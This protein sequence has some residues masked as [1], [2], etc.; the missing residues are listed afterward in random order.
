V[1]G[2]RFRW[3][4]YLATFLIPTAIFSLLWLVDFESLLIAAGFVIAGPANHEDVSLAIALFALSVVAVCSLGLVK[5]RKKQ[6]ETVARI[7]FYLMLIF[8][9][10]FWQNLYDLFS[11]LGLEVYV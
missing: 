9:C 8:A 6:S 7:L 11:R 10:L 4:D 5:L 2:F 1:F 3:Y